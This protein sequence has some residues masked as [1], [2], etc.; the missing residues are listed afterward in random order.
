MYEGRPLH[1]WNTQDTSII[2]GAP[3][4][5]LADLVD[6]TDPALSH[7]SQALLLFLRAEIELT[8]EIV[9]L[10]VK[11]GRSEHKQWAAADGTGFK[12]APLPG[13]TRH[14]P[15]VYYVRRGAMVK[16]GTT[17][18]LHQRMTSLLPEE[19]LATEPGGQGVEAHRHRQFSALRVAGHREW[20]HAGP[21]LQQHVR[22]IRSQHGEPD[23][24]LPV[25]P[26]S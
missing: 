23:A 5:H 26:H 3:T 25:L 10:A 2:D 19:I 13:D 22:E 24:T 11:I 15:V 8:A 17:T 21:A 6:Q 14:D 12:A 9:L 20:F 1:I 7:I 4:A 18:N 16:I